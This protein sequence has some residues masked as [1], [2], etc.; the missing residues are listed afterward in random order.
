MENSINQNGD[1]GKLKSETPKDIIM[2]I[3]LSAQGK[4]SVQAP[5]DGQLYDIPMSLYLMEMAKDHIKSVNK[6]ASQPRI[7]APQPRIRD[8]FRRH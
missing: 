8:I 5:G 1:N 2:T 3:T 4:L 6:Q 7:V